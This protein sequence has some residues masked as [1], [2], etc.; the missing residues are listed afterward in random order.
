[1]PFCVQL[2]EFL[3]GRLPI[4][5][6]AGYGVAEAFKQP[7][8]RDAAYVATQQVISGMRHMAKNQFD[9]EDKTG[10]PIVVFFFPVIVTRS[11]IF[12]AALSNETGRVEVSLVDRS[13]VSVVQ[14]VRN[15][16]VDVS[17]VSEQAVPSLL[18][19]LKPL[20]DEVGRYLDLYDRNILSTGA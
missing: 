13:A 5:P 20:T 16:P 12:E 11:P 9:E 3:V 8:S 4:A 15:F 7:K 14:G 1:M 19:D 2:D 10:F 17:I 6:S 18:A